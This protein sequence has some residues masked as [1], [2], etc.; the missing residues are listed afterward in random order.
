MR[1]SD[2]SSDVC[3]SDLARGEGGPLLTAIEDFW[4][5]FKRQVEKLVE[6]SDALRHLYVTL[7][8]FLTMLRGIIKDDVINKG[9]DQL[10]RENFSDWFARHGR[11]ML[12]ISSPTSLNTPNLSYQYPDCDTT[13]SPPMAAGNQKRD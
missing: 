13:R 10:D 11:S 5:W 2:W 9:F 4:N 1:I 8:Y 3:S 6:N 12:P 7:D